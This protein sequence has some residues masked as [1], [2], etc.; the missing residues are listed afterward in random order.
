[1]VLRSLL[2]VLSARAYILMWN[3]S[4]TDPQFSNVNM[5]DEKIIH[6]RQ[7]SSFKMKYIS[8]PKEHTEVKR[9]C[10]CW[11]LLKN[12]LVIVLLEKY[13]SSFLYI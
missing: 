3:I 1:M 6:G 5:N 9:E 10:D 4:M 2:M 8:V 11:S 7:P 13:E 12:A